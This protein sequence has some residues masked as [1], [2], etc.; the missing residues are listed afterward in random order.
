MELTNKIPKEKER[1][2]KKNKRDERVI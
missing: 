1:K 2:K